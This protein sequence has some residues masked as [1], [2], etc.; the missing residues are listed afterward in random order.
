MPLLISNFLFLLTHHQVVVFSRCQCGLKSLAVLESW[1]ALPLHPQNHT[2]QWISQPILSQWITKSCG[3]LHINCFKILNFPCLIATEQI[4]VYCFGGKIN[5]WSHLAEAMYDSEKPQKF[6]RNSFRGR[7]DSIKS[8]GKRSRKVTLETFS[9]HFLETLIYVLKPLKR[10]FISW[11]PWNIY[12]MSNL[13]FEKCL[14]TGPS[15]GD[16][17]STFAT[18]VRWLLLSPTRTIR[19][20]P[21]VKKS[22]SQCIRPCSSGVHRVTGSAALRTIPS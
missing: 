16:Q 18:F 7:I 15:I 2:E 13:H 8:A 20:L 10:W 4:C 14:C 1:V 9:S 17:P 19:S 3:W 21:G 6:H 22:I 5:L 12:F 11:N